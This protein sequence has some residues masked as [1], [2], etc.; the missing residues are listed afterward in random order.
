LAV[1]TKDLAD[2]LLL[3]AQGKMVFR[4]LV[5]RAGN[6]TPFV[7]LGGPVPADEGAAAVL[8]FASASPM[9]A[10]TTNAA[11]MLLYGAVCLVVLISII[12]FFVTDRFLHPLRQ[13]TGRAR[14][15]AQGEPVEDIPA[16]RFHDE[17]GELTRAFNHMKNRVLENENSRQEFL[18]S[19]SHDIRTPLTHIRTSALGLKEGW[20]PPDMREKAVDII[21][22]E[23]DRLIGMTNDLLEAARLQSGSVE[24]R[25]SMVDLAVLLRD[26][27]EAASH[28]D[29]V[30]VQCDEALR[31]SIDEGLFRRV[32]AN[33]LDNAF[34]Y[35]RSPVEIHA[36][37]SGGVYR[38]RVR[39]HGDGL[40]ESDLDRIFERFYRA[41]ATASK[42]K[43]M[44]IG[45][46]SA[47]RSLQ[48]HGGDI[49]ARNAEGG[50]LEFTLTWPDTLNA[51]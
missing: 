44:G 50:G 37:S 38:I 5:Y 22:N 45:L 33:L 47:R 7:F 19:M 17:I 34:R 24:L 48:L 18:S 42:H 35:G 49:T 36:D 1:Q 32:L 14:L 23:S 20:L 15:L 16:P 8:V 3:I 39:D 51:T 27:V 4:E 43:G 6:E 10:R 13:M 21:A 2:D 31:A 26:A 11:R 30:S 29:E 12:I 28:P 46:H 9:F 40:P 25:L 41:E